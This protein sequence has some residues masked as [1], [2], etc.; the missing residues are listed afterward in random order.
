MSTIFAS[1]FAL[2]GIAP[3]TGRWAALDLKPRAAARAIGDELHNADTMTFQR[4]RTAEADAARCDVPWCVDDFLPREDVDPEFARSSGDIHMHYGVTKKVELRSYERNHEDVEDREWMHTADVRLTRFD[5]DD[6]NNPTTGIAQVYV[7][8]P[9]ADAIHPTDLLR[10]T[11]V[12]EGQAHVAAESNGRRELTGRHAVAVPEHTG[13][14]YLPWCTDCEVRDAHSIAAGD[15]AHLHTGTGLTVDVEG[16]STSSAYTVKVELERNDCDNDASKYDVPTSGETQIYMSVAEN[17]GYNEGVWLNLDRAEELTAALTNLIR[18]GSAHDPLR[19][20]N[21]Y[22]DEQVRAAVE[23]DQADQVA[24]AA[25][26]EALVYAARV[27]QE[28]KDAE[29]DERR[30]PMRAAHALGERAGASWLGRRS[31]RL[32]FALYGWRVADPGDRMSFAQGMFRA[33]C[34]DGR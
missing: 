17:G 3:N 22:T 24:A 31:L 11:A 34:R 6:P 14:C 9:G 10:L 15:H 27:E 32:A 30:R 5:D 28:W 2:K 23:V 1:D 13:T 16:S 21:R 29:E 25:R 33:G 4:I 12:I 8:V 7:E 20:P 18:S 26:H 19:N